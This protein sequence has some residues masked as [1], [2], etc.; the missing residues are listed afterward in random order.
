MTFYLPRR[1]CAVPLPRTVPS[2][3]GPIGA[4]KNG[5]GGGPADSESSLVYQGVVAPAEQD[6]GVE[7]GATVLDPVFDVMGNRTRWGPVASGEPARPIPHRQCFALCRGHGANR[8][9]LL[10]Q[11]LVEGSV[12]Q[13]GEIDRGQLVDGGAKCSSGGS[14]FLVPG[15]AF[16]LETSGRSLT[17]GWNTTAIVS[18]KCSLAIRGV[19]H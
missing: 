18:N 8:P 7:V 5:I 11:F 16:A 4:E 9:S 12:A 3:G 14:L 13:R 6:Q 1:V 15:R 17:Y 10:Y 2:Q 19:G